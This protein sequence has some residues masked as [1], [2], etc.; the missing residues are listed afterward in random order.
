MGTES[1][2]HFQVNESFHF[3]FLFISRI[4]HE[5][6]MRK[7]NNKK[8]YLQNFIIYCIYSESIKRWKCIYG[9]YKNINIHFIYV[10]VV[11]VHLILKILYCKKFA[12]IACNNIFF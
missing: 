3:F 1:E 10:L 7:F 6:D 5:S 4:I 9:I 2:S 8:T 11:Q 12:Y